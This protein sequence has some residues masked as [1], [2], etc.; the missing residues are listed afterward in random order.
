MSSEKRENLVGKVDVAIRKVGGT[1]AVDGRADVLGRRYDD[2]GNHQKQNGEVV[3]KSI[4][5]VVVV[6]IVRLEDLPNGMHQSFHLQHAASGKHYTRYD[7]AV[8][9]YTVSKKTVHFCFS[10]NFARIPPIL[11]IF[12]IVRRWQSV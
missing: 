3:V 2:H 4:N 7:V 6:E 8:Y 11:L 12:G 1:P 5:H 10:Q 9:I